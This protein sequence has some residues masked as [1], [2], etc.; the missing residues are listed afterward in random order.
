MAVFQRILKN[1]VAMLTSRMISILQQVVLPPVFIARYSIAQF[2]EWGVLSG[3]VGALSLL[4]FGVQT[5]MNQDL[6]VR[7]SRGEI[8]GYHIRQSTALRLL[9]GVILVTAVL[10]LVLFIVPLD[11]WLRLDIG[12]RSAQWTAYLLCLQVLLNILFGY[13]GGIFMGV[14]L[15]HR[16]SHWNNIQNLL[17]IVGLLIGVVL[18]LP[19]PV[20]AALQLFSV[21]AAMVGVLIDIRRTSPEI[22]P[23]LNY[24]DGSAVKEILKPSG[25]F[26]LISICTFLTFQAPLI[27]MQRF[28]GAV[29]V[30]GFLIMRTV[31]SMCRQVLATFTTSMGS[32]ITILFGRGDWRG[33]S[34]LYDY[35][36]RFVFFLIPVVNTGALLLSPVLIT[37]WMHKKA[38]L[39]SVYPYVLTAAIAMVISLKEHKFQFQFSTNTHIELARL[40]FFSYLAMIGVSLITVRWFGVVG[41]LWTWLATEVFQMASIIR[42]NVHLFAHYERLKFTYL[43]RLISTC[44]A[45]LLVSYV[46]LEH[47]SNRPMMLQV[48]VSVAGGLVVATSAWFLFHVHEVFKRVQGI[49]SSK[50]A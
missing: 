50:F 41:F 35:S 45:A 30:A 36:E 5:F 44:V 17:S 4:N 32:E 8:E 2:G 15:A 11:R 38:E 47:I 25:Y 46:L 23:T 7:F 6:A 48:G 42:L 39:F 27:V 34:R 10:C 22:F 29:A 1:L 24:W 19:F 28:V 31:F 26:G 40:M 14:R 12:R 21:L 43:R 37:V 13:F 16:G 18:H 49:F 33:I 20:L 9:C 3:A